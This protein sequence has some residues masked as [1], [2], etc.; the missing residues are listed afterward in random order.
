[1]TRY[2]RRRV[3]KRPRRLTRRADLRPKPTVM[4]LN[5]DVSR[6]LQTRRA[7]D[8]D[9][10]SAPVSR[11]VQHSGPPVKASHPPVRV[12]LRGRDLPA[13]ACDAREGLRHTWLLVRLIPSSAPQFPRIQVLLAGTQTAIVTN[14]SPGLLPEVHGRTKF[15]GITTV[16]IVTVRGG[17][18]D[19]RSRRDKGMFMSKLR[20]KRWMG[21]IAAAG[22]LLLALGAAMPAGAAPIAPSTDTSYALNIGGHTTALSEG[23]TAVYP[24]LPVTPAS[25][26]KGV[27][28]N[29]VYP[30]DGTGTLTVTASAGVYHYSIAMHVPATN[31][32][33]HFSI[34]DLTSGLSGGSVLELVFAGDIPTSK[35]H[36]HT[37]SGTLTGNAV[38]AGVI[39]AT[40]GPNAT[41]YK[42]P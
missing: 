31:F 1:M 8:T 19:T 12:F 37:Y 7:R 41:L 4:A 16:G 34:T 5:A 18:R 27:T 13:R 42:Y 25:G 15:A 28:P 24:M 32:I 22:G 40:V 38:F 20:S 11:E 33:G 29:V 30:G 2:I 36:G 6:I 23:E 21:A 3:R 39:V 9:R 26:T 14:D 10:Q 17:A 35:L